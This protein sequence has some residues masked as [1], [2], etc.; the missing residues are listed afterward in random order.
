M[1]GRNNRVMIQQDLGL[2]LSIRRTRKAVFLDEMNLVLASVPS[3]NRVLIT[4]LRLRRNL[5]VF[6]IGWRLHLRRWSKRE[7]RYH[8][9]REP[10]CQYDAICFK[11][12][13]MAPNLT[14]LIRCDTPHL[15][16]G[17]YTQSR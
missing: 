6:P 4:I 14:P 3:V 1:R 17:A 10:S 9:S 12:N 7:G 16:D 11:D 8:R 2:N 5:L 13:S 15:G